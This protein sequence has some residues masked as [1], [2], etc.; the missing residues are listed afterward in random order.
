METENVEKVAEVT[1]DVKETVESAEEPKVFDA[2]YVKGL[3]QEAAKYRTEAKALAEKAKA[4]DEYTE[5]QKTEQQ[6]VA[7]ALA[8]AQAER[9]RLQS[10]LLRVQIISKKQLP[11]SLAERLRGSTLE[12]LEAD[13]DALMAELKASFVERSKPTP[14]Q[15]G[16]GIVGEGGGTKSAAEFYQEMQKR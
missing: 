9:D 13:A 10:E 16:A 1:T 6:K 7:D 14:E 12:E 8:Q 5:S 3:R 4:Y 11:A 2:D 15:T